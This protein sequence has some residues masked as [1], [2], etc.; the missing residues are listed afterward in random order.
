MSHIRQWFTK[1]DFILILFLFL[2]GIVLTLCVFF[3]QS[4]EGSVVEVHENGKL[5]LSLPLTQNTERTIRTDDGHTNH[6]VIRD[7]TVTMTSADCSDRTCVRTG[8]IRQAGQ[9]IVCLPHRLVLT[10]VGQSSDNS[11]DAVVQ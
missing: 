5:L 7:G 3:P 11:L 8:G 4:G 9:S 6:F 1:I 2:A 10:I